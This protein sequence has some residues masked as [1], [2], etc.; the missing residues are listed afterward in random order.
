MGFK[1]SNLS[2]VISALLL[3]APLLL[4]LC[5]CTG[6]FSKEYFRVTEYADGSDKVGS[7]DVI[8]VSSWNELKNAVRDM[9]AKHVSEGKLVFSEY[10]GDL[11]RELSQVGWSVKSED[12][13]SGYSVDYISYDLNHIVTY[14]EAQIH[15]TYRRTENEVNSI[16]PVAGLTGFKEQVKESLNKCDTTLNVQWFSNG[17]TAD[18]IYA[19]VQDV[20]FS[21]PGSCVVSPEPTISL[22]NSA[23]PKNI[24]EIT[25]NYG[26]SDAALQ[27]LKAELQ[28]KIE[29][30]VSSLDSEEPIRF[31]RNACEAINFICE[32]DETA[33]GS[34]AYSALVEG[35][36]DS[37]GMALALTVLCNVDGPDCKVI[38]GM[39]NDAEHY[40]NTITVE[41]KN[42]YLDVLN[43]NT[44]SNDGYL[45]TSE[46]MHAK[47]YTWG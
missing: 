6:M 19:A 15:I 42:G 39:L 32:Y 38:E 33:S 45:L 28:R 9:V 8:V 30:I 22:Y 17:L 16:I 23:S 21:D 24:V 5:G 14:Y 7:Y 44:A 25:F 4:L 37:L 20:Y 27:T 11:Q 34:S 46:Q 12:A 2:R 31:A 40:W 43:C 1:K 13:L 3:T 29:G 26:Y 47:G 36:A 10:D 35:K 18:K 41:G